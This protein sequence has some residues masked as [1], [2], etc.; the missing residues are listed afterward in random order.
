MILLIKWGYPGAFE[1][2]AGYYVYLRYLGISCSFFEATSTLTN[3][4]FYAGDF[5]ADLLAP[6]KT[7]KAGR[8]L[9]DLLDIYDLHCLINKATRKTKTSETLLDLILTNNKRTT[10]TSGVVD[11]LLSD[12]SLVYTVL[13]SSAPR[14]RSRKVFSRI[15]KT[16]NQQNFVRDMQM[17]PFHIMNLFDDVDD[18]LYTFEQL[19]LDILDEHAPLKHIHIRGKQVPYMTEEWRK[20][21]RHRN[22]LWRIF[23]RE[24]TDENY[25]Q[26]KCQRNKCT[27]LRRKAI[28]EHV[29][30]KSLE[31]ENPRE[32]WS[33]YRPFLNSKTKQANDIILKEDNMVINDKKEIADLFNNYFVQ[34]ADCAAQVNEVD[35]GQD[36]EKHPSILA[37]HER[38]TKG[39]FKFQHTN[40]ALVEKLLRDINVRKSCG[41]DMMSPRLL[42]ESAA[43][44]AGPI[45]NIINSSVDLCKYPSSWKMGQVTPLFKKDDELNKANYR[46]VTVLP[47]LNNVYERILAAQLNDFYC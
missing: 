40:Q 9:L 5:N 34:I 21:I 8:K 37:I 45:A 31:S 12:H 28:R 3:T 17:V 24:R 26:Y 1:M 11:T 29:R 18:K 13:R 10:L 38:N 7:P 44:I 35:Y 15:L 22:K 36:Y 33:A 19:Y 32:F 25:E 39:Y 14:S 6:D 23:R 20:A 16:F 41:H 2:S 43:V 27:S 4:V 30:R 42:K 46:P 47:A